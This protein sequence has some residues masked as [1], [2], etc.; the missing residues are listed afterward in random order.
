MK[1]TQPYKLGNN[2]LK[3]SIVMA[4]LTRCRAINNNT[5]NTLMAEYYGQR[6]GA[7][8]IIAEGTSPSVNGLGYRNI[9][10]LF[11]KD[12]AKTWRLSTDK[13]RKNNG[14]IFIQLMHTGRIGHQNNLPN[15]A[16]VIG[17]SAIAQ[18]G[19][20]STYD[21]EKQPYPTPIEMSNEDIE[22]AIKEFVYSSKLAIEAGFHGV[23]I[24]CAH[25]YLPNQFINTTSNQRNDNYGGSIENRCRFVLT[26]LKETCKEIGSDKVGIRISPFSYAD[27]NEDQ[28]LIEETYLYLTSEM[29][30][31]NL[32]Y[33]HLSHMGDANPIKFELFNE[34][35]KKYNG[36]LIKCGDYTRE[37]AE[38]ALQNNECDLIA[39]GRDYIANPDLSERFKNNWPLTERNNK[40]WYG[41]GARGY[42]DYSNY[43]ES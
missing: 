20:I 9:P 1:L 36:T 39:F 21:F 35:R 33:L 37:T 6:A 28:K 30:K 3:S 41:D 8:L 18:P 16:K 34:I 12:H 7:G 24:H 40:E 25:G 17:P 13:V 42:T 27:D 43:N 5:P 38:E 23:E 32:A 4:P 22:A 31:L 2:T 11:T 29:N 26:I 19:E 10:G 15:G 14:H